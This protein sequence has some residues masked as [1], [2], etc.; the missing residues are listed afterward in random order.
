MKIIKYSRLILNFIIIFG[1]KSFKMQ[2]IY[3]KDI[4]KYKHQQNITNKFAIKNKL[5]KNNKK[6]CNFKTKINV[7][8]NNT[9]KLIQSCNADTFKKTVIL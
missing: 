6:N 2:F 1:F 7:Y 4:H 8:L 3:I 9:T 5:S